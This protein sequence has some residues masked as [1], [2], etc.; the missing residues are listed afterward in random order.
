M[1]VPLGGAAGR[2][3]NG[4]VLLRGPHK[5]QAASGHRD[6]GET[7]DRG[8]LATQAGTGV[9]ER[10]GY[11]RLQFAACFDGGDCSTN[12]NVE[13]RRRVC[14]DGE[15]EPCHVPDLQDVLVTSLSICPFAHF[16]ATPCHFSVLCGR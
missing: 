4:R 8:A 5:Q 16:D 14:W 7:G 2:Q 10:I 12:G 11:C 15:K 6:Q 13:T 3:L 1:E 9:G